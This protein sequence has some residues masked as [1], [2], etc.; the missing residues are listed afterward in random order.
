MLSNDFFLKV[1][2]GESNEFDQIEFIESKISNCSQM[3]LK[4]LRFYAVQFTEDIRRRH[5][6]NYEKLLNNVDFSFDELLF[7]IESVKKDE[8]FVFSIDFEQKTINNN[9]VERTKKIKNKLG[10]EL[11]FS[12]ENEIASDYLK[13]INYFEFHNKLINTIDCELESFEQENINEAYSIYLD[14]LDSLEN[15]KERLT[16]KNHN[17]FHNEKYDRLFIILEKMLK[18]KYS[19]DYTIYSFLWNELKCYMTISKP[20]EFSDF[21]F[22][23]KRPY[24]IRPTLNNGKEIKRKSFQT[25]FSSNSGYYEILKEAMNEINITS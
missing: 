2:E 3:A 1:Y 22:H 5:V 15:S 20:G 14:S 19:S 17:L 12:L 25:D 9:D 13:E 24:L 7:F 23:T 11:V 16:I 10:K 4:A 18:A 21:L 8:R 6:Y